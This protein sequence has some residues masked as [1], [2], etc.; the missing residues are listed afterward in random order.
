MEV[1]SKQSSGDYAQEWVVVPDQD[2]L[3]PEHNI[4]P[5]HPTPSPPTFHEQRLSIP[6]HPKEGLPIIKFKIFPTPASPVEI[7]HSVVK[8]CTAQIVVCYCKHT[9]GTP[10]SIA[11]G[12]LYV[13]NLH[14]SMP[15]KPN[16]PHRYY[17][18][19][20]DQN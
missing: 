1:F 18:E 3:D 14:T 5:P 2:I 15:S 11:L 13:Y 4:P 7:K 9:G 16:E 19:V 20:D 12:K 10:V 8:A 17:G 6:N